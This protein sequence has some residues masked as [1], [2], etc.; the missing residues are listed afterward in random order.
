ML[1]KL[2]NVGNVGSATKLNSSLTP[3]VI[4][5]VYDWY[6]RVRS[7]QQAMNYAFLLF[8]F[9][10][11][12][13]FAFT[14]TFTLAFSLTVVRLGG[15]L[16]AATDGEVTLNAFGEFGTG[17]RDAILTAIDPV[18][19]GAE[20]LVLVFFEL[21]RAVRVAVEVD[22]FDVFLRGV[23]LAT[24]FLDAFSRGRIDLDRHVLANRRGVGHQRDLLALLRLGG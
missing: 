23:T 2:K 17:D 7:S 22:R 16:G 15:S 13:A 21:A 1:G 14:F 4:S 24:L 11:T 20:V 19:I 12:F 9:T 10:F 6:G 3:K 5:R 8:T 18:T